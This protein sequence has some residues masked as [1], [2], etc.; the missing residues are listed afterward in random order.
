MLKL[1]LEIGTVTDSFADR[2]YG[3]MYVPGK[4]REG[5]SLFLPFNRGVLISVRAS[6][7]EFLSTSVVQRIDEIKQLVP[8]QRGDEI[9]FVRGEGSPKDVAV[10]WGYL[11]QWKIAQ[12]VIANRP[13]YRVVQQIQ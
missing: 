8:P 2:G 12:G 6:R 7:P 3:F 4:G 5:E 11:D 9:I 1:N 13:T 10:K